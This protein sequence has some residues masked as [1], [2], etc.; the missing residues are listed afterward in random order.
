MDVTTPE[1]MIDTDSVYYR[2]ARMHYTVDRLEEIEYH[3]QR[4]YRK[5]MEEYRNSVA[6]PFYQWLESQNCQLVDCKDPERTYGVDSYNVAM[7][8]DKLEF[9]TEKDMSIFL[10]R[11]SS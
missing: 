7:G 10:L 6:L 11:W 3:A 4:C 8:I 5:P 2:N 9:K 1:L